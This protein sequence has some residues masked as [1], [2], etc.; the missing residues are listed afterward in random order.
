MSILNQRKDAVELEE[1]FDRHYPEKNGGMVLAS[2]MDNSMFD[3][4]LGILV[5]LEKLGDP[6]FWDFEVNEFASLLMPAAYQKIFLEGAL[7]RHGSGLPIEISEL[8]MDL[9]QDIVEL[10]AK[11]QRMAKERRKPK[12]MAHFVNE[13]ARKMLEFDAIFVRV[14]RYLKKMFKGQLLMRTRFFAGKEPKEVH[15][16]TENVMKRRGTE[17]DC[18]ID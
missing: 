18:V 13:F 9:H 6:H 15:Q 14:D 3:N 8:G 7:G 11:I 1:I 12:D 10:Y 5:F 4:D 2:D 16:L 17:V